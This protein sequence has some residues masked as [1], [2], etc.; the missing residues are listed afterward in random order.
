VSSQPRRSA[1]AQA[2]E[3]GTTVVT[4]DRRQD[5]AAPG[6]DIYS[7]VMGGGYFT[8]DGTSMAAP[9]VTGAVAL[10]VACRGRASN[11]DG[12]VAIR[13]ALI[14]LSEPQASWRA[15]HFVTDPDSNH[16]GLVNVRAFPSCVR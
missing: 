1:Y 11:A 8:S 6:S 10:Y 16:E 2:T 14:S 4:V 3:A 9:H 13:Q 15:D 7:T 12:V 5:L